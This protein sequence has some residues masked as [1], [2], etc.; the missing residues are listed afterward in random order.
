MRLMLACRRALLNATW[1]QVIE[2]VKRYA[3]YCDQSG[4]TGTDFVQSPQRFIDEGSY[5]ETFDYQVP[6][7]PAVAQA[8]ARDA[9]R[10][11]EAFERGERCGLKRHP[12]ESI[13]AFET[14]CALVETAPKGIQNRITSLS[15]RLKGKPHG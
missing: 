1:E 6:V 13:A 4:K 3:T 5:L 14:R 15:E 12:Q 11:A 10:E 7:D 2:G 8:R 9:K